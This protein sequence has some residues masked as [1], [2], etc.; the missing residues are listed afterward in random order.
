MSLEKQLFG[1]LLLKSN[2]CNFGE[3][4]D[5]TVVAIVTKS[6]NV[7]RH[8][9]KQ[10]FKDY[11]SW[12][13]LCDVNLLQPSDA[14]IVDRFLS[15]AKQA[16]PYFVVR[17]HW[18]FDR[19]LVETMQQ[20]VKNQWKIL[21][22]GQCFSVKLSTPYPLTHGFNIFTIWNFV[23]VHWQ[24]TQTFQKKGS[25]SITTRK[26]GKFKVIWWKLSLPHSFSVRSPTALM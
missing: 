25:H 21:F 16:I 14:D 12:H 20:C 11:Y 3:L 5:P 23:D 24:K 8:S 15:C 6:H 9:E 7:K 26:S 13:I 17:V 22:K 18:E 10:V 4:T 2:I 19:Y 1:T